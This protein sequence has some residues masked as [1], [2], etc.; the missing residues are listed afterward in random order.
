MGMADVAPPAQPFG[1][2]RDSLWPKS[3]VTWLVL[4][5]VCILISVQAVSPTRRWRL[6]RSRGLPPPAPT[7]PTAAD[8]NA[9]ATTPSDPPDAA[10]PEVGS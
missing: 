8:S 9:T 3:V 1:V 6:R 7:Q 5:L 2:V 10:A 4:S